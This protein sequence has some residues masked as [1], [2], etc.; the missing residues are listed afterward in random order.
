MY[1]KYA[2]FIHAIIPTLHYRG[3]DD[4]QEV[5][6]MRADSKR[7]TAHTEWMKGDV[8][9][10]TQIRDGDADIRIEAI[11]IAYQSSPGAWRVFG[12]QSCGLDTT[13]WSVARC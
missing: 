12:N 4:E 1:V 5:C 8:H 2:I 6:K 9:Y 7:H 13:T 10:I 3:N 11:H